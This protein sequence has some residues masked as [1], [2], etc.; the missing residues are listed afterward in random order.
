MILNGKRRAAL[1][2]LGTLGAAA[3]MLGAGRFASGS[4]HA[5][6]TISAKKPGIDFSDLHIF[7]SPTNPQ[8]VVLSMCVHPLIPTGQFAPAKVSFDE[9]VLYQFKID[10]NGDFREDLVIQA[11]FV[12]KGAGQKVFIAGPIKPSRV[13]TTSVFEQAHPVSGIINK[14]FL[15][16]NGMRVF[17]GPREDPFPIDLDRLFDI[18]PDRASPLYPDKAQP[19]IKAANTP[20]VVGWRPPGEAKDFLAGFNVLS[21]VVELP[22]TL[23]KDPASG[24]VGKI[25]VWETA[26]VAN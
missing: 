9:D 23:L 22:R 2:G 3:L 25:G 7:P 19:N 6:T 5:G 11:K 24:A 13:G 10:T 17:A 14:E 20:K 21:I 4:D 16:S 12:G 15:L 18:F 26:S 1:L 8:K